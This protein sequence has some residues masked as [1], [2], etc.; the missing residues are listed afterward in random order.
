MEPV[1]NFYG[2]TVSRFCRMIFYFKNAGA[3]CKLI[4]FIMHHDSSIKLFSSQK[5]SSDN[6]YL[7]FLTL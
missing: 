5:D 6:I 7:H 3:E 1:D 4:E 2:L